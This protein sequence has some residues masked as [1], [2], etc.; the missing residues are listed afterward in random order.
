MNKIIE[1]ENQAC[2]QY[3][4]LTRLK[5]QKVI[6]EAMAGPGELTFSQ[7]EHLDGLEED[8]D[9]IKERLAEIDADIGVLEYEQIK[10]ETD[11]DRI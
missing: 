8:I 6:F 7:C 9:A 1:L 4:R 11:K 2:E 5:R 3:H 10:Q